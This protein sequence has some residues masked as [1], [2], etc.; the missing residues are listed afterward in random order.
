MIESICPKCS[1][2]YNTEKY[3]TYEECPQCGNIFFHVDPAKI[4]PKSKSFNIRK[5]CMVIFLLITIAILG[6]AIAIEPVFYCA[7]PLP[8]LLTIVCTSE[9]RLRTFVSFFSCAIVGGIIGLLLG[10]LITQRFETALPYMIAGGTIASFMGFWLNKLLR[11][12]SVFGERCPFCNHRGIHGDDEDIICNHCGHKPYVP[13]ESRA[14]VAALADR[15]CNVALV[16]YG[17]M[18]ALGIACFALTIFFGAVAIVFAIGFL[19]FAWS[20]KHGCKCKQCQK[21]WALI[22]INDEIIDKSDAYYH[23]SSEDTKGYNKGLHVYQNIMTEQTYICKY[24]AAV[25]KRKATEK[26]RLDD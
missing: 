21:Q 17:I 25:E 1:Y 12:S 22:K 2:S 7:L 26:K 5:T 4:I 11:A 6:I 3:G 16:L 20:I 10:R 23:Y 14:V 8:L 15:N 13:P 24:C 19:I 9:K 18:I